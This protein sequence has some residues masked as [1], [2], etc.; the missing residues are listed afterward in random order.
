MSRCDSVCDRR[1]RLDEVAAAV[2][3]ELGLDRLDGQ[4]A[5]ALAARLERG[6]RRARG[7]QRLRPGVLRGLGAGEDAIDAVVVQALVGADERAV[8][9]RLHGLGAAQLELDGDRQAIDAG[10]QRAG[11]VGQRLG[12]HRLDRAGHVDRGRAPVGLAV[13]RPAGPHVGRDVGDVH[14]HAPVLVAERLAGDR[15]V[16]VARGDGVDGEGRQG[17]EVAAGDVGRARVLGGALDPGGNE[18]RRPRSSMSA[19]MTSRATSGR[20]STRAILKRPPFGLGCS[21]AR[22]PGRASRE[23]STVAR[24]P[25]WKNGSPTRKR[26]RCSSRTTRGGAWVRT[27]TW[28]RR[29]PSPGRAP[30]PCASWGRPW[31]ARRG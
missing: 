4:R 19:S 11:V 30:R 24:R 20:P 28:R 9:G 8:E 16:E 2:E 18:R 6:R 29:R 26:P 10:A 15:V 23:R 13:D 3:G 14:P 7:G 12:Q 27:G 5:A 25:R 1:H 22:R 31:P 21:S 17:G